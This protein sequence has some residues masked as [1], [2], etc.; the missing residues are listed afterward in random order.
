MPC[1]SSARR[2]SVPTAHS[3]LHGL[4]FCNHLRKHFR[5]KLADSLGCMEVV[6][7]MSW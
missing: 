3:L 7:V 4:K 6:K 5:G 1:T 2:R